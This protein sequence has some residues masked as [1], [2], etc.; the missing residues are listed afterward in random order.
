MMGPGPLIILDTVP[1]DVLPLPFLYLL[2]ELRTYGCAT[3]TSSRILLRLL[4][5]LLWV[6]EL[7]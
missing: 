5:L 7:R 4:P 6:I 2:F 1:G 3:W